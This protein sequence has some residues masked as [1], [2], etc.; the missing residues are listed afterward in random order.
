MGNVCPGD[1]GGSYLRFLT[2]GR[3]ADELP[4]SDPRDDWTNKTLQI[5]K[6]YVYQFRFEIGFPNARNYLWRC[7]IG[8]IGQ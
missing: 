8:Q 7:E 1:A 5:G 2:N 4:V 6:G 3:E